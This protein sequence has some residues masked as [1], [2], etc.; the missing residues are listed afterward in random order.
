MLFKE[1]VVVLR[2]VRKARGNAPG[3]GTAVLFVIAAEDLE[4]GA[5]GGVVRPDERD[6]VAGV[7]VK[8]EFVEQHLSIDRF[9]R[10]QYPE[11]SGLPPDWA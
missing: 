10:S 1:M 7:H 2:K 6:L 9:E 11:Y 3:V 8:R 4:E 5:L